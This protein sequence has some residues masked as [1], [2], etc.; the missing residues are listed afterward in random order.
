MSTQEKAILGTEEAWDSG[1]L[2]SDEQYVA[3]SHHSTDDL[4]NE[5]LS[6]QPI[7][8]RLQKGLIE[9]LKTIAELN[10]IG[11]QPLV[12][13]ALTRFVDCEMKR[14]ATEALAAKRKEEQLA[15][16]IEASEGHLKRA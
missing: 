16:E 5:A 13:Q 10:G 11:Y 7:S 12:R 14:I 1:V 8:I 2:G 9:N 6:L 3:V 15:M 4:I